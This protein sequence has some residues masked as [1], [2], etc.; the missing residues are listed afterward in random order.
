MKRLIILFLTLSLFLIGYKEVSNIKKTKLEGI[1]GNPMRDKKKILLY[2]PEK[3]NKKLVVEERLIEDEESL[4]KSIIREL[5]KGSANN[6][7]ASSLLRGTKVVYVKRDGNDIVV[8]LSSGF[9]KRITKEIGGELAVFSI[10]NSITEIPGVKS[11]IIKID[12]KT[13]KTKIG[14]ISIEVP[15]KRNRAL[16]NRNTV[17]NPSEALK[18]QMIY[19]ADGK[20]L[21]AYLLMSDDEKNPNRKYYSEYVLEMEEVKALGFLNKNFEVLEYSFDE[22]KTRAKVKVNFYTKDQ[23]GEKR[24]LNTVYFNTVKIEGV[25]MVDWLTTQ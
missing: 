25:W 8:N 6:E 22:T 3:N 20:W 19:E 2:F 14:N 16:F 4:E 17:L 5:I 24:I 7:V 21:E 13:S 1:L 18:K 10:V 15:L 11:V 9:V 12:G 23:M